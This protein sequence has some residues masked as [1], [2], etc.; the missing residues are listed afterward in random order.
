MLS[1]KLA[2][3]LLFL[4]VAAL[5]FAASSAIGLST[6]LTE[7]TLQRLNFRLAATVKM[8]LPSLLEIDDLI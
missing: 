2:C 7:S 5:A 8:C 3:E 4:L 6:S 1:L